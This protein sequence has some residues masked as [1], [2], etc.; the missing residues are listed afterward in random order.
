VTRSPEVWLS[1][2]RWSAFVKLALHP[3]PQLSQNSARR[4]P[5][6]GNRCVVVLLTVDRAERCQRIEVLKLCGQREARF[7]NEKHQSADFVRLSDADT[8][9]R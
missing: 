3:K 1:N 2:R 5:V 8:E 6:K 4:S 7:G 9:I